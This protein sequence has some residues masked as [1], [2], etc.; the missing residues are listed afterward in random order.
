MPSDRAERR[1]EQ[2]FIA[3]DRIDT[4]WLLRH[5]EA[6][7]LQGLASA[8]TLVVAH[9]GTEVD[10]HGRWEPS[11]AGALRSSRA[12]GYIVFAGAVMDLDTGYQGGLLFARAWTRPYPDGTMPDDKCPVKPEWHNEDHKWAWGLDR[13]HKLLIA[14]KIKAQVFHV[15]DAEGASFATLAHAHAK[16]YSYVTRAGVDRRIEVNGKRVSLDKHMEQA[17]LQFAMTFHIGHRKNGQD[18]E[19]EVQVRYARVRLLA[20]DKKKGKKGARML[21]ID[22][23]WVYEPS[24]PAGH[25]PVDILL[26]GVHMKVQDTGGARQ[27]LEVWQGRWVVEEMNKIAKTGCGLECD[28]V[29]NIKGFRRLLAV[30]WPLASHLARWT[31]AARIYPT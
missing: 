27:M 21:N 24:C 11:D 8:G 12:R 3:N 7:S 20:N 1:G 17:P 14:G 10:L 9:D 25:K 4:D 19:A 13:A 30:V 15:G 26:L 6:Y 5:V 2:R 23:V 29:R 28:V 18:R 31:H 16:R 22:A